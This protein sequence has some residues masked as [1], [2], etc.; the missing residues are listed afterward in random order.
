V[1]SYFHNG[2]FFQLLSP[3]ALYNSSGFDFHENLM[4]YLRKHHGNH[5]IWFFTHFIGGYLHAKFDISSISLS[6][7]L[8]TNAQSLRT[9]HR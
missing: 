7:G 6:Y 9:N 3:L 8:Q 1:T 4:S 2:F 5:Y